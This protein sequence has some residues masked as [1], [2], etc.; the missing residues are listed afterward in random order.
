MPRLHH[1][2]AILLLALGAWGLPAAA[3]SSAPALLVLGDSLSAG[4]GIDPARGWVARLERRLSGDG[5]PWRVVN[6]SISGDTTRGGRA[7]LPELLDRWRPALVVIELGGND[8][9]RGI[10]PEEMRANL[11]AMVDLAGERDARVLLVG[12]RLP[13]NYGPAYID[14]FAAVFR[15][16][17][18]SRGVPLVPRLLDGVG[19]D[20]GLMQE[21]GIHPTAEAQPRLLENVWPALA[22]LL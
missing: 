3:D 10:S 19:G 13:P 7:R 1:G 6:A 20:D 18:R 22:P 15:E 5:R 4:Y 2:L 11:E 8:G 12:V 9:L 16:V 21:D 17:A 14:A